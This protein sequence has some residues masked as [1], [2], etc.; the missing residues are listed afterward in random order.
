MF[1]LLKSIVSPFLPRM[2]GASDVP[3][4][5]RT[6]EAEVDVPV[7]LAKF[8]LILAAGLIGAG[9]LPW[10]LRGAR[11]PAIKAF[12]T[13]TI[14]ALGPAVIAGAGV[15]SVLSGV[16]LKGLQ[17]LPLSQVWSLPLWIF[18][19]AVAGEVLGGLLAMVF[20]REEAKGPESVS[21]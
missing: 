14:Y 19:L 20:D 21:Q 11:S 17:E 18:A 3:G 4:M 6:L 8:G 12:R 10:L 1:S 13:G 5:K 15:G 9:L 2:Q 16:S 7:L